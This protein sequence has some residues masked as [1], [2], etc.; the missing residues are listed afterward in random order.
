M[1]E[2]ASNGSGSDSISGCTVRVRVRV[3]ARVRVEDR[4]GFRFDFGF[5][6]RIFCDRC[7]LEASAQSQYYTTPDA[8]DRPDKFEVRVRVTVAFRVRV[9]ADSTY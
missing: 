9:C 6:G 3:R 2:E 7:D 8:P 5:V 4:F 1:I